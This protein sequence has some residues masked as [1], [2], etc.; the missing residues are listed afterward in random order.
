[1]NQ[2]LLAVAWVGLLLTPQTKTQP[3]PDVPDNLKAP[4][5]EELILSAHATGSQI[6]VCQAGAD[7]KLSWSLKAP[8]AELVDAQG[9]KVAH[10]SAGPTWKH[11]DGSEVTGK[12]VAKQDAP[13][14]DAIPWLLLTAATHT[15]SGI[16]SRVTS[17]QR[18]HTAG[19]LPPDANSCNSSTNGK[20]SKSAYSADYYFFAPPR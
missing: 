4:A 11:I 20:E 9:K 12:V 13:K 10:H 3:P 16:F 15:G 19:G 17:I 6:Y 1:M 7:K 8:D 14:A 2:L 5:G 18:L